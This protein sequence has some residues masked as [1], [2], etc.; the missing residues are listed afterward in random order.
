MM[1]FIKA[2]YILFLYSLIFF[3]ACNNNTPVADRINA[4]P[5]VHNNN[6]F[7][8]ELKPDLNLTESLKIIKSAKTRYKV[9]NVEKSTVRVRDLVKQYRGYISDLRFQNNTYRIESQFTIKIPHANFD[10]V[11]DSINNS[12]EFIDF[13]NITTTDVTEEYIDLE[14]RLKTKTEVKER[15]EVILRKRAKTVKDILDTEEKLRVLQE[16]IESSQGRLNYLKN[17]VLFSTIQIELYQTVDYKKPPISYR[18]TFWSKS[19]E[20]LLNGWDMISLIVLGAINIWP[21]V[22]TAVIIL[23][24][25]KKRRSTKKS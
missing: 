21:I 22:I 14:T 4:K 18:K 3:S 23:I 13:E 2:K 10:S 7:G 20:G 15:Y 11:I 25:I 5:E 1:K 12:V 6:S 16:E 9:N 17:R 24:I 19:K 8:G